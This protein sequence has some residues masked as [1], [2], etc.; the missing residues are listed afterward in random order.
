MAPPSPQQRTDRTA[1]RTRKRYNDIHALLA[2][3]ES[4]RS[5]GRRLGLARGTVRR[6]VHAAIVEELLVNKRHRTPTQ[7]AR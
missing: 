7:P 6:F 4:L 5:I 2:E 3:G 1:V